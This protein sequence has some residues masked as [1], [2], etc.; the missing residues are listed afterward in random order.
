VIRRGIVVVHGV[1]EQRRADQLDTVV[2]SL[3][4]FL[5]RVAGHGNVHLITR[6]HRE[7]GA[8]PSA[9][10]HITP[11]G[12]KPLEE[13]HIREAWWAQSFKPSD[14]SSVLGWAMRA[15]FAHLAST[16]QNILVRNL[17][18]V[19]PGDEP[20][21]E[22]VGVWRVAAAGSRLHYALDALNWIVITIGY[23]VVY[24]AGLLLLFPVYLFLVLPLE[25]LWPAMAS[26]VLRNLLNLISGNIGDQHAM[27]NRYVAISAAAN[28]VSTALQPFLD[29]RA[30]LRSHAVY[31]TVTV[32][33]HSGGAVVSYDALAGEEVRDWVRDGP[34]GRRI[35]WITVGS[36]LN[37]AWRM[38]ARNK[39]R[40]QAFWHRPIGRYVNWIDIY[41]RYD[42]VPQGEPPGALVA[43]VTAGD[44]Q[45]DD[46]TG[47][48]LRPF[49]GVRVANDDWPFSD[50]GGYWTNREEVMARIVDAISDSRLGREVLNPADGAFAVRYSDGGERP[51]MLAPALQ[52]AVESG[53]GH[54]RRVTTV[55]SIRLGAGAAVI[56]GLLL[57]RDG[58]A[59]LGGW[60]LG[61]RAE[62]NG[63]AWLPAG[64]QQWLDR[65]VPHSLLWVDIDG[66]RAWLV[67]AAAILLALLVM[68]LILRPIRQYV[69][70]RRPEP[71]E[72]IPPEL[73]PAPAKDATAPEEAPPTRRR[74]PPLS[75]AG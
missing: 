64:F 30:L 43:A 62:L 59:A 41:A 55:Q 37:L 63:W 22:G 57:L 35:T 75:A 29:P 73:Q 5:S 27:T 58:V 18:L 19:L 23:T 50:H 61:E 74:S 42:P 14:T 39:A 65:L 40:D 25:W 52:R 51:H 4:G 47:Q 28:T 17:R 56:G 71:D 6:T 2:E 12:G 67:G 3:V 44:Q 31:D 54:R 48:A 69:R 21:P 49:V 33:A 16:W 60:L 72:Q 9:T 36:G 45:A 68:L 34:A 26:R 11:P 10:I 8:T 32:I 38:H 15:F 66:V 7:G 20:P 70:W 53:R 13:W 24:L 1:G 46:G